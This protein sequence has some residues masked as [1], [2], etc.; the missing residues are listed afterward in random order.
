MRRSQ[1]FVSHLRGSLCCWLCL[2]IGLT[3]HCHCMSGGGFRPWSECPGLCAHRPQTRP[4]HPTIQLASGTPAWGQMAGCT[5]C[6]CPG[7]EHMAG[8]YPSSSCKSRYLAPGRSPY[9]GIGSTF[10]SHFHP[11]GLSPCSELLESK[12]KSID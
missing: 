2:L 4:T 9:V 10:M 5:A 3:L 8:V 7:V 11:W 1:P 12:I 6:L